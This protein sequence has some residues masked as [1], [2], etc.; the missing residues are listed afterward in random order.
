MECLI[1]CVLQTCVNVYPRTK[2]D[3][4]DIR[5]PADAEVNCCFILSDQDNK[6]S[7]YLVAGDKAI[8]E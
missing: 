1:S 2:F 8:A 5:W 4:G 7:L 6:K 3:H